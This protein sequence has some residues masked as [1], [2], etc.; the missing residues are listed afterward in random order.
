MEIQQALRNSL[1]TLLFGS[2]SLTAHSGKPIPQV[3][4]GAT[5]QLEAKPK[6]VSIS[7][8]SMPLL[9]GTANSDFVFNLKP[10]ISLSSTEFRYLVTNGYY[11]DR[12]GAS[13]FINLNSWSLTGLP[14]GIVPLYNKPDDCPSQFLLAMGKSC[15]LHYYVDRNTYLNADN[16][17]GPLLNL[18]LNY[19]WY[20]NKHDWELKT[21]NFPIN[22]EASYTQRILDILPSVILPT[23]INVEPREIDGLH[24]DASTGLISGTPKRIGNYHFEVSASNGTATAAP[25]PLDIQI[26]IDPKDKPIFKLN[27]TLPSAMLEEDFR[28]NL[29]ELLQ[30]PQSYL[31]ANQVT[32]SIDQ[33]APHPSWLEIDKSNPSILKGHIPREAAGTIQDITVLASSNTGGNSD[34]FTFQIPIAFD[35][36]K[37][38]NFTQPVQLYGESGN[39]F[40]FDFTQYINDPSHDG[41]VKLVIDSVEPIASWL[42][43]S[44]ANPVALTGYVDEAAVGQKYRLMV[45]INNKPGGS[46]DKL[47]IPLQVFTDPSKTPKFNTL[48]PQLPIVYAGQ[49]YTYD[50]V[51]NQEISPAYSKYPYVVE[52]T[53]DKRN[54][55]WVKIENNKLIVD[56]PKA[57]NQSSQK[58]SVTIT[59]TPGGKSEMLIIKLVIAR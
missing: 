30:S 22:L 33:N 41:T 55:S 35:Q 12:L 5:I 50:F 21:S 19:Y 52:L 59:N 10:Y 37:K 15:Y 14:V 24:F 25:Q 27:P 8:H 9:Q 45:H 3:L 46:S 2:L 4:G 23:N 13:Q 6:P 49:P 51:T 42:H 1:T 53:D 47:V 56:C 31:L 38:P 54:P 44:D 7:V 20:I 34:P 39:H 26:N 28:F 17:K 58:V 11:F 18:L 48:N 32:F 43:V 16:G 57:F 36:A 29:M 40:N